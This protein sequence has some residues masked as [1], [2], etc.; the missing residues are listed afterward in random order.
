MVREDWTVSCFNN[1]LESLWEKSLFHKVHGLGKASDK[2]Q[3]SDIS[4]FISPLAIK[5]KNSTASS[6]GVVIVGASMS[7]REPESEK[8]HIELGLNDTDSTNSTASGAEEIG[9]DRV[10]LEHYTVYALDG[11][12]GT[13]VWHHDG[14]EVQTE[15]LSR[16]LPQLELY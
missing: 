12:D 11:H 16:S 2:F 5:H 13:L 8:I 9:Y 15:Q 4:V 14:S 10:S 1:K 3:I 7:L 6:A